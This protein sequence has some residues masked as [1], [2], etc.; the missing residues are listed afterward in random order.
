MTSNLF[1]GYKSGK[2]FAFRSRRSQI[3]KRA[4]LAPLKQTSDKSAAAIFRFL[5]RF[6]RRFN[7]LR[8]DK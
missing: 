2:R 7:A 1:L 6:W 3:G 5:G 4:A 8:D